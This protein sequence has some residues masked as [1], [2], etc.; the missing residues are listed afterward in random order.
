[1]RQQRNPVAD[2]L[3]TLL[4]LCIKRNYSRVGTT[5]KRW[6]INNIII[7]QREQ[8]IIIIIIRVLQWFYL[9]NVKLH[10]S[11]IAENSYQHNTYRYLNYKLE[12]V[13]ETNKISKF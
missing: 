12:I 3:Y 1:M 13:K 8:Y 9:L 6:A 4:L 11:R 5:S 10:F 7:I 2:L